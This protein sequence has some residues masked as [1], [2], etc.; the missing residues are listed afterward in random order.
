MA[1][2]I[3]V[4]LHARLDEERLDAFVRSLY[5]G[6]PDDPAPGEPT[7]GRQYVADLIEEGSRAIEE[8]HAPDMEWLNGFKAEE[9]RRSFVVG[10]TLQRGSPVVICSEQEA[11]L[12]RVLLKRHI[13]KAEDWKSKRETPTPELESDWASLG[14]ARALLGRMDG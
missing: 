9:P 4:V 13:R 5:D 11:A 2:E 3:E 12:V 14:A 7:P 6:A 10:L 1:G 8:G